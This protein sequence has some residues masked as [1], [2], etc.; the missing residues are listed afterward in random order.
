MVTANVGCTWTPSCSSAPTGRRRGSSSHHLSRALTHSVLGQTKYL[1]NKSSKQLP[2]M[3]GVGNK[4]A[5]TEHRA[6]AA[7]GNEKLWYPCLSLSASKGR[8]RVSVPELKGKA[9]LASSAF[10]EAIWELC[11]CSVCL[12]LL[13]GKKKTTDV[14]L[15]A[16]LSSHSF[17]WVPAWDL[18]V[19]L[20]YLLA[21]ALILESSEWKSRK[22]AYQSIQG[23]ETLENGEEGQ[24]ETKLKWNSKEL[25]SSC[26]SIVK[27]HILPMAPD[28]TLE[29]DHRRGGHSAFIHHIF[30]LFQKM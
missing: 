3:G 9:L 5:I 13:Q 22:W 23:M 28:L 30:H 19:F 15:N 25:N 24:V 18:P 17:P 2:E 11:F 29:M 20:Q 27:R 21:L 1:L 4:E 12:L 26:K 10:K 14:T 16:S 6:T 7:V 8:I